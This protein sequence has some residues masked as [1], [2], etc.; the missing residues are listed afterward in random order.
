[1]Q[2]DH[3]PSNG[4]GVSGI[5]IELDDLQDDRSLPAP[6]A[7]QFALLTDIGQA[8]ALNEDS[9][10]AC[11]Q[12]HLSVQGSQS[13]GIF[14]VADGMGGHNEGERA[15]LTAVRAASESL[16]REI[17]LPL[18]DPSGDTWPHV[19]INEA[20]EHAFQEA[21]RRVSQNVVGG[22][23][24]LTA[25]LLM[26]RRVYVGHV[27]DCRLY[28]WRDGHLTS[29]TRDHS[30]LSRL[31]ELGEVTQEEIDDTSD[32]ERRHALYRAI[33]QPQEVEIDLSSRSVDPQDS[34]LLCSDGLWGSVPEAIMRDILAKEPSP[35]RACRELVAEANQRGGPDNIT[36]ILVHPIG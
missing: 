27:G 28:L 25:A 16:L 32:D 9:A 31:M 11:V 1:M 14:I 20:I 12:G 3:I 24:T 23:T 17:L 6:I 30:I 13:V 21:Q 22:G 18:V 29:L 2:E 4:S 7:G 33:G 34:L 26:G 8:R 10:F 15:S 36:V 5:C 19:P 35:V